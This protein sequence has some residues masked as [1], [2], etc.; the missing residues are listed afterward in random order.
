MTDCMFDPF[1]IRVRKDVGNLHSLF[2]TI[3]DEIPAE[4]ILQAD[5]RTITVAESFA[6]NSDLMQEVM[7]I[8]ASQ[9]EDSE[10]FHGDT[11]NSGDWFWRIKDGKY[12]ETGAEL[13]PIEQEWHVEEA[14]DQSLEIQNG[15]G[16]HLT[17]TEAAALVQ[18]GV[19]YYCGEPDCTNYH[20]YSHISIK[21]ANEALRAVRGY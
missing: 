13:K 16:I 11:E 1:V 14:H 21:E 4:C 2:L 15:V 10:A 18:R 8:Y 17:K 20:I 12:W 5:D 6:A 7:S 3:A 9:L 19:I